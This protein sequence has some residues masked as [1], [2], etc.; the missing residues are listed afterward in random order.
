M[1]QSEVCQKRASFVGY[2]KSGAVSSQ[3]LSPF[4]SLFLSFYSPSLY[5]SLFLLTLIIFLSI[6]VAYTLCEKFE[7]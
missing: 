3:F 6:I 1:V 2:V 5:F 4:L 7:K